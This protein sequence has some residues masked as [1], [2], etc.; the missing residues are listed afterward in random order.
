MLREGQRVCKSGIGIFIGVA[1]SIVISG[2]IIE[3]SQS[4]IR[5]NSS[6]MWEERTW[7]WL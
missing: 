2:S 5:M 3:S 1:G 7:I 4:N 6:G